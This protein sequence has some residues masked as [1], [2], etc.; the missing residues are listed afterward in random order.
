MKRQTRQE[1]SGIAVF[2]R[3]TM[4]HGDQADA[5]LAHLEIIEKVAADKEED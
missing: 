1:Q 4:W 2:W 5:R 3:V